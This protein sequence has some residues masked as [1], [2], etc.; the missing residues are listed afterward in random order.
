MPVYE[1]LGGRMRDKVRVYG[2]CK[3]KDADKVVARAKLLVSQGYTAVGYL[4]P[5]LEEGSTQR[6]SSR[7]RPACTKRWT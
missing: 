7:T 1:L 6:G 4:N 2:H 5:F 3:G